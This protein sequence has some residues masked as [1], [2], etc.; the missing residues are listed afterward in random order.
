MSTTLTLSKGITDNLI[1]LLDLGWK[2]RIILNKFAPAICQYFL[3]SVFKKF[4][5]KT[6][7]AYSKTSNNILFMVGQ[8]TDEDRKVLLNAMLGS[9]FY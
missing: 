7:N 5:T 4:K 2:I 1:R 3:S 6:E 8:S 9:L